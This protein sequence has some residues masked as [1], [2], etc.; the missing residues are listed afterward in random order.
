M[1]IT[2]PT[3][4]VGLFH[5]LGVGL[6]VLLSMLGLLVVWFIIANSNTKWWP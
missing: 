2:I 3:W 1:T 5:V 6:V 4:V